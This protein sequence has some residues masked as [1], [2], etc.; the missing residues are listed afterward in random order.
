MFYDKVKEKFPEAFTGEGMNHSEIVRKIKH[1][2]G[3]SK[4]FYTYVIAANGR[5]Y[6]LGKGTNNRAKV[7]SPQE[8]DLGAGGHIKGGIAALINILYQD[9]ERIYIPAY[10]GTEALENEEE[11]KQEF[12]FHDLSVKAMSNQLFQERLQQLQKDLPASIYEKYFIDNKVF[13]NVLLK[14]LSDPSGNDYQTMK[15]VVFDLEENYPG[16]VKAFNIF[17]KGGFKPLKEPSNPNQ[18]SL[19]EII[20]KI[21]ES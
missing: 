14:I 13:R 7:F 8:T 9:T 12:N 17:F 2:T 11:L 10:T 1:I 19:F 16:T 21:L 3:T 15:K 6:A 20:R 18:T 5:I 4:A